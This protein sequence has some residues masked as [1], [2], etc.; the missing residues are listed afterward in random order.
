MISSFPQHTLTVMFDLPGQ[1][2]K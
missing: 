1:G 2:I